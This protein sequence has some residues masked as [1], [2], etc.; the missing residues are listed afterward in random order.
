MRLWVEGGGDRDSLRRECAKGFRKYVEKVVPRSRRMPQIIPCG[1][2]QEAFD[3]F[4][5]A[6]KIAGP[7]VY[8]V[9]LVDAEELVDDRHVVKP[10]GHL[11]RRD[12]WETPRGASDDQAHLMVVTVEAWLAADPPALKAR[13]KKGF[14][15]E[16]LLQSTPDLERVPKEDLYRALKAAT[17]DT[18]SGAYGKSDAFTLLGLIDPTKVEARCQ[19]LA[20]RFH[21]FLRAN[22]G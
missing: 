18:T 14:R 21:A 15:E 8:E 5:K 16:A 22:C 4:C 1:G 19:R 10:W 11:A 7:D 12:R 3:N 20:P 2:R 13:Y 6:L 9:L 17:K